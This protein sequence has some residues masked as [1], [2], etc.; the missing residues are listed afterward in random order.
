MIKVSKIIFEY[1]GKRVLRDVSF[2]IKA[3][4]ITALVG[5]NGAG[6]T[7]LMRCMAA[8]ETPF[9]GDIH[10][11]GINALERPRDVHRQIGYLSDFFGLY[12][13]LTVGKC[14][15]YIASLHDIP[16]AKIPGKVK[17]AAERLDIVPY[18]DVQVGT[19]SRGL[20]QRL[21]IAQSLIHE[22]AIL[23]L[24]EPASGLDPEARINLSQLF[25]S[26]QAQGMTLMVSSH[27]LAE[28]EDYCTDMLLL[29]D[30]KIIEHCDAEHN[31]SSAGIIE[32]L[33]SDQADKYV[34]LLSEIENMDNISAEGNR[35]KCDFST[36][37]QD[38]HMLLKKLI[39]KDIPVYSFAPY[40]K[41]LHEIYMDYAQGEK[42]DV[43]H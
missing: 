36:N 2:T 41:R 14:L 21:G 7:T 18:L 28:L 15:T 35:I 42:V 12:N 3:G 10:V 9:S 11:N 17:L 19:L 23:L 31:S 25:L 30:G 40:Q 26:L 8:L 20:R 13:D 38:L 6:K 34:Q 16:A 43:S 29:R 24:D 1:P 32:I 4:S 39:A 33:L 22:P 27:I 37:E 5:P